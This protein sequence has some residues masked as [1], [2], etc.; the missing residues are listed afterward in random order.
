M[1]KTTIQSFLLYTDVRPVLDLVPPEDGLQL[2]KTIFDYAAGEDVEP[3]QNIITEKI[4][5]MIR[6]KLEVGR[7]KAIRRSETNRQNV[8]ARWDKESN[9]TVYDGI[10]KDSTVFDSKNSYTKGATEQNSTVQYCDC[11]E[12]SQVHVQVQNKDNTESTADFVS[13]P[14]GGSPAG[15]AAADAAPR[16]APDSDLFTIDQLKRCIKK[17]KIDLTDEGAAAF[18]D[19]MHADGWTLY[20]KPVEKRTITRVLRE[21][22]KRHGEYSIADQEDQEEEAR[23]AEKAE[24]IRQA[25]QRLREREEAE[26]REK[27]EAEEKKRREREAEAKRKQEESERP[28]RFKELLPVAMKHCKPDKVPEALYS[29]MK[30]DKI[31]EYAV[32]AFCGA[33]DY[34]PADMPTSEHPKEFTDGYCVPYWDKVRDTIREYAEVAGVEF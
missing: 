29:L 15:A 4:W 14:A 33:M 24:R 16:P 7:E 9:T 23:A 22:A 1:K 26:A 27:A 31:S 13:D 12:Q 30:R 2:L 28:Q 3:F 32:M 18:L 20:G 17:N 19:E 5:E 6:Q 21:W 8:K 10:Q 34:F 11:T 25:E